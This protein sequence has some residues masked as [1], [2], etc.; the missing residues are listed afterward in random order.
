[1]N[2]P[3]NTVGSYIKD[4]RRQSGLT[5]AQ[6]AYKIGVSRVAYNR[7]E[8][9]QAKPRY[10]HCMKLTWVLAFDCL[11]ILRP[12]HPAK[13]RYVREMRRLAKL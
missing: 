6:L 1:M 8:T 11:N 10:L 12:I 7:W 3:M 4:Q 13:A 2:I 9:H 5:Q